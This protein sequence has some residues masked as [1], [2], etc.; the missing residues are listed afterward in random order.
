MPRF[1]IVIPC[2]NNERT[3][4]EA[5]DTALAQEHDDF[6]VV[7][8]DNGSQDRSQA[9]IDGYD[10]PRLIKLLNLPTLG[11]TD[12]W[13][14]AYNAA[15]DCQYLVTLHGDDR[16]ASS[17]LRSIAEQADCG[18][19]P[20]IHGRVNLIDDDGRFL[21]TVGLPLDYVATASEFRR[22]QMVSNVVG[23]AGMAM[24][25]DLFA[26]LGGWSSE[27]TSSQDVEIWWQLVQFGPARHTKAVLGDYRVFANQIGKAVVIENSRWARLHMAEYP[28]DSVEYRAG[29]DALA[30]FRRALESRDD[31]AEGTADIDLD[32]L[33]GPS[34]PAPKGFRHPHF[35]QR[36][37]RMTLAARTALSA[38][39]KRGRGAF[40]SVPFQGL[41]S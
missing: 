13:N 16:L 24:R 6:M 37:Y 2:F 26:R 9:I 33:L 20:L 36:L 41:R 17:A 7:V 25:T 8:G 39:R 19:P 14:R 12:N 10:D 5:I 31:F 22:I 28:E 40:A 34:E 18:L 11:K 21:R 3:I 27:W 1:C 4:A 30:E 38:D 35:R 23:I 32:A 29:R 15:P